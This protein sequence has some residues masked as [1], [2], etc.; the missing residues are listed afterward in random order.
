MRWSS[1]NHIWEPAEMRLP[2]VCKDLRRKR[3]F[4]I[5]VSPKAGLEMRIWVQAVYLGGDLRKHSEGMI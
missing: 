5:W 4:L 2:A 3:A 1:A